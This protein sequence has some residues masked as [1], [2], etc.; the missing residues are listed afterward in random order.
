MKYIGKMPKMTSDSD[1]PQVAYISGGGKCV[2]IHG[3]LSL[4]VTTLSLLFFSNKK[5]NEIRG[6]D[7]HTC[8]LPSDT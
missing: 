4:P 8:T 7:T 5:G 2:A 3:S 1:T 6:F